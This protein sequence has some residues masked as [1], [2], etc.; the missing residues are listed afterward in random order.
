MCI[1]CCLLCSLNILAES[2]CIGLALVFRMSRNDG[3]ALVCRFFLSKCA[4]TSIYC[5]FKIGCIVGV[6]SYLSILMVE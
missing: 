5:K 2:C 4:D 3:V 6:M 1:Q